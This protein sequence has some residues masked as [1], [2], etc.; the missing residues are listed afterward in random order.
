MLNP[1]QAGQKL[2]P[3]SRSRDRT[4]AALWKLLTYLYVL[5]D[6][7]APPARDHCS[8]SLGAGRF[9]YRFRRMFVCL[10]SA[11]FWFVQLISHCGCSYF[12]LL[13]TLCE[14]IQSVWTHSFCCV[15]KRPLLCLLTPAVDVRHV[16]TWGQHE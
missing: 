2:G 10:G 5:P 13:S 9:L 4:L 16:G 14:I 1:G 11:C 6:C 12:L 15:M 7:T 3:R 8:L